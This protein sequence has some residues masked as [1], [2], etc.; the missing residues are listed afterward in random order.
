[1]N[2]LLVQASCRIILK[3]DCCKEIHLSPLK[4]IQFLFRQDYKFSLPFTFLELIVHI[5]QD[6]KQ[7]LFI[8]SVRC[9][10]SPYIFCWFLFIMFRFHVVLAVSCT[11]KVTIIL[12]LVSLLNSRTSTEYRRNSYEDFH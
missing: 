6:T 3:T 10:L 12:E 7:Y 8:S 1:M 9:W 2:Q 5:C 4:S 11:L